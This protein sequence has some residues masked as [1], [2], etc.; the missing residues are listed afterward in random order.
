MAKAKLEQKKVALAVAAAVRGGNFYN[1][2]VNLG[3][4]AAVTASAVKRALAT[5]KKPADTVALREGFIVGWQGVW[6][7]LENKVVSYEA[8][9][10]KFYRMAKLHLDPKV[11]RQSKANAAKAEA[12]A[13][14]DAGAEKIV[15][16][17]SDKQMAAALLG[18]TLYI[19]EKQRTVGNMN[20]KQVLGM[21]GELL[22]IATPKGSK[23]KG[24]KAD[25]E[26]PMIEA[27]AEENDDE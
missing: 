9:K 14:A 17:L 5:C 16:V 11:N 22:A 4:D 15:A 18:I 26:V 6:W 21:L 23:A 12:K 13:D 19:G 8:A 1:D 3:Q 2:G 25:A 27:D 20:K 24:K 7:T 10:R